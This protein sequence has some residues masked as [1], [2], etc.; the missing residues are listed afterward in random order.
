MCGHQIVKL[1]LLFMELHVT[2][3]RHTA[4]FC[5]TLCVKLNNNMICSFRIQKQRNITVHTK[6]N[7]HEKKMR[8]LKLNKETFMRRKETP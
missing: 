2:L 3:N 5:I 8:K 6:E 7:S 4:V 1:S